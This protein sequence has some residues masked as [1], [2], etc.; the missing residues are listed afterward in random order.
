MK[1]M[2]FVWGLFLVAG[3]LAADFS[4]ERYVISDSEEPFS[5]RVYSYD[6]DVDTNG[7]LH[8]VY[9]R[10]VLG[11][12]SN[13]CE[14][15]Y[16]Y[17]QPSQ[18]VARAQ[19]LTMDGKL[20]S[21]S[22][23]LRI[24][25]SNV[26][27][28]C[29]IKGKT[30]PS[31]SLY[32]RRIENGVIGDE[33]YVAAGGWHTRMTVDNDNHPVFVRDST[34]YPELFVYSMT[35]GN[36]YMV[37]ILLSTPAYY[38]MTA[39]LIY[40]RVKERYHLTFSDNI[41]LD[42]RCAWGVTTCNGSRFGKYHYAYSDDGVNWVES[43]VNPEAHLWEY[44]FW[45]GLVL[46][47]DGNPYA[48]SFNMNPDYDGFPPNANLKFGR[49]VSGAWQTQI[50]AGTN[51]PADKANAG[52]AAG[53]AVD[54]HG[55][56]WGAWDNSP[57]EACNGLPLNDA[58]NTGFGYSR[59]GWNWTE[60]GSVN[61]FSAEGY[62]RVRAANGNVYILELGNHMDAKLYLTVVDVSTYNLTTAG[63]VPI[64]GDF[65]GD[66]RAGYGVY[67][68]PS[69]YWQIQRTRAGKWENN[70]GFSGTV[71]ITGDFDG[72]E[73]LDFGCY[74]PL[75]GGWYI[76]KSR[77]GFWENEFGYEGTLPITG[78][79]DGD[80]RDDFGCYDPP[81]G[82]WYIYKSRE[83][84]WTNSFGYE[85]TLPITGDFDG[86]GLGDFGCYHPPSGGWYIYKS[87]EGFWENYFGYEGTLPVTGDFDGDGLDDFGCYHPA[88]GG[89]YIY[90]SREGFWENH[91]GYEGTLPVV[92]DFDGDEKD[93]FGCYDPNTGFWYL[94]GSTEGFRTE[95]TVIY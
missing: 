54:K 68:A 58:G 2:V 11:E 69:G 34:T 52:A 21:I 35:G 90:K 43:T 33:Q 40:D 30:D 67:Y 57:A 61:P 91:F 38:Y 72:D 31:V 47:N 19:T 73:K 85:G 7:L 20:G 93:D 92:A 27:H 3:S 60:I 13:R 8:I 63:T 10:P 64:V 71:P 23:H 41:V 16:S 95:Q 1:S 53:I 25:P 65:D 9:A 49:Y 59:D 87:R 24:G 55:R 18:L 62:C 12:D 39:D 26:V 51:C 4:L 80:G 56:F 45:T 78:D 81:S 76:Y 84:F 48:W 70:F 50:I 66:G 79:F 42:S 74:F 75:T 5:R 29:Y 36:W 14:I 94:Y 37:P 89:W 44:E 28:V 22:T 83:G 77:E 86:D 6:M 46:D 82:G 32:Y 88:S 15:V 17:G